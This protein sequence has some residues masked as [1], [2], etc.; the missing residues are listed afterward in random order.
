MHEHLPN[1]PPL[2]LGPQTK[3]EGVREGRRTAKTWRCHVQP[4][5]GL[6]FL[7]P[8]S[9]GPWPPSPFTIRIRLEWRCVEVEKCVAVVKAEVNSLPEGS[10]V[11]FGRILLSQRV[12]QGCARSL[13]S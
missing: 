3:E 1:P 11:I 8:G 4:V 12:L 6:G 10:R 7:G 13:I 5:A 2:L 9:Q